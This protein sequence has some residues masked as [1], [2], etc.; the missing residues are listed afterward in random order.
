MT[1]VLGHNGVRYVCNLCGHDLNK[2]YTLLEVLRLK[3]A[4][5]SDGSNEHQRQLEQVWKNHKC[6]N[7]P[8]PKFQRHRPKG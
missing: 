6:S 7:Q 5:Y 8:P 4:E 2:R 1:V 3:E